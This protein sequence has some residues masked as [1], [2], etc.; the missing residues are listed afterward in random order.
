MKRSHWIWAAG[1]AAAVL[2]A[3]G[4]ALLL[5]APP[6]PRP[7]KPI[8]PPLP[9][10][11]RRPGPEAKNVILV[12]GRAG[13]RVRG[14]PLDDKLV[15]KSQGSILIGLGG[16]DT[17]QA[18]DERT[19]IVERPGQ[20]IDTIETWNSFKVPPH[21][22]NLVL[23]GQYSTGTAA[24]GGSLL[25][26]KGLANV[27]ESGPGSDTMIADPEAKQT[28][29][30]FHPGSGVDAVFNFEAQGDSHDYIRLTYPG[31]CDFAEVRQRLTPLGGNDT[32]LTLTPRDKILIKGIRPAALRSEH[33]LLCFMP[34][35]ME[36]VF[37]DQFDTLSLY[38]RHSK[39]GRWKTAYI[40]A[41]AD[42]QK[43]LDARRLTGN[44]DQQI[45]VD[46]A[47]AGNPAVSALPLG[48]NPFS[49]ADGM[50]SVRAWRLPPEKRAKLWGINFASGLLT[51]EPSFTQTYGYYEIRAELPQVKGMFPAFWLLPASG[52]WP[53]EIDI[54]E[55]VAQDFVTCG[56]VLPER[57]LAFF[58]RFHGGVR[59]MHRYGV[60]WTPSRISWIFDGQV[61]GSTATPPSLNQPMYM[62]LNLA[63]G[64]KWP[65][66]PRPDFRSA[67]MKVDYIRVYRWDAPK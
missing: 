25:T 41:P 53:P 20:G 14:S 50:L 35:E 7:E 60:L 56:M 30:L 23:V 54:M 32:L 12:R 43:S 29:F 26:S 55:N 21:V 22:E 13:Q 65:G 34:D 40:H 64:G 61:V 51:S 27:L 3:M 11:E 28:V 5:R 10:V 16:N 39:T 62:L 38:D 52:K 59:G 42:G 49:A 48:L 58:V 9:L 37:E 31:L 19:R 63:V 2:L 18:P 15:E 8:R 4:M 47:Y 36:L 66:S 46:P 57:K 17:Y 33:F 24:R 67:E 44:D 45:Y 6:Q 1:L